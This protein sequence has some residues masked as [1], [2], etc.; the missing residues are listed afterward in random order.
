[1]QK[2]RLNGLLIA[3]AGALLIAVALS[4]LVVLYLILTLFSVGAVLLMKNQ[5]DSFFGF[6]WSGVAAIFFINWLARL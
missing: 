3:I 4:E 5:G 2:S 1:M 6:L